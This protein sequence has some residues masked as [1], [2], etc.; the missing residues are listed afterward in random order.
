MPETSQDAF[1]TLFPAKQP[2]SA[3]ELRQRSN[4][5]NKNQKQRLNQKPL[6]IRVD[7]PLVAAE[8][9]FWPPTPTDGASLSVAVAA[10]AAAAGGGGVL[11]GGGRE[12]RISVTELD[13]CYTIPEP[14]GYKRESSHR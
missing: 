3:Q 14:V 2:I 7:N 5:V 6:E 12:A 10:A 11:K 1:E 13:S 9:N 8:S 4:S